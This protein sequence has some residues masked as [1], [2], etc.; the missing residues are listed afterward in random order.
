MSNAGILVTILGPVPIWSNGIPYMM[1]NQDEFT[2]ELN[3]SYED[4]V[5]DN[6]DELTSTKLLLNQ[7]VQF[8]DV[9]S[10]FCNIQCL[11]SS[12]DQKPFYWDSGHLTLTGSKLLKKPLDDIF[13][14]YLNNLK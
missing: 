9:A 8:F 7:Y 11:Y 4:Y 10:V 5:Q 3:K 12:K 1:W 6:F 2:N 13:K 14:N